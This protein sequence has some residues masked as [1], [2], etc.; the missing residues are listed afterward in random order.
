[1]GEPTKA[2]FLSYA[3]QDTEVARRI[4][5]ALRA[6]GVEVWF[7]QNELTG[8][9]AWDAKIRQQIKA[10]ALFVPI[11]SAA[12]QARAE[13]YFRREWKMA[14]ERTH[15]MADD[16]AFL[17]PVVIDDVPEAA[18]RVPEKFRE[19]QWT[20]LR[21]DE[22]PVELAQRVSRLLARPQGRSESGQPLLTAGEPN[23]ARRPGWT[24]HLGLGVG[25]VF[26]LVFGLRPFWDRVLDRDD[27]AEA[28]APT[29]NAEVRAL[30]RQAA[31][32][33][34]G[35]TSPT[36][37]DFESAEQLIARAMALD[38]TDP[39]IWALQSRHS[40]GMIAAQYDTS[41]ERVRK[42][43]E[44]A[45]RAIRLAP[46][47][48][49]ARLAHATALTLQPATWPEAEQALRQLAEEFP[50]DVRMARTLGLA[51]NA[52]GR[53]A[54]AIASFDRAIA[55]PG[56]DAQS[57]LGKSGALRAL[58][59]FEGAEARADELIRLDPTGP[60]Q[61]LKLELLVRFHGDLAG[62]RA[63]IDRIPARQ[64]REQS[65]AVVLYVVWLNLGEPD[66]AIA[67]LN[68]VPRDDLQ[69]QT[70]AG[71]K[72]YLIGYA[73]RLAGRPEAARAEWQ[74]ALNALDQRL[75]QRANDAQS[76]LQRA[77]LLA[78]LGRKA[79]AEEALHLGEQLLGNH[80]RT[81]TLATDLVYLE[82]GYVNEVI[83]Y[84]EKSRAPG[85]PRILSHTP[86]SLRIEPWWAPIR[87]DPRFQALT[88]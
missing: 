49:Y 61:V 2:V 57:L 54:E 72:G 7:D 66:R 78:C 15:D 33:F 35:S 24:R 84:L 29:R 28:S 23:L 43:T 82:L 52:Y 9:D 26:A 68:A 17:F 27:P 12:T 8:G 40:M 50:A 10:C 74:T 6:R 81:I 55:A 38:A 73:H 83:A 42:A 22:T 53:P 69:D 70:F 86:V 62:A 39:E 37:P 36:R 4:A 80:S 18:A 32:L 79:E 16:L 46:T 44:A 11:I 48:P 14:V 13:G 77:S 75:A 65:A 58:G 60:G 21:L 76:H 59:D 71:P 19:V 31:E 67:A 87:N 47:D 64:L 63:L 34:E 85:S 1:M 3:S 88:R 5:E 41:Q 20:R 56:G 51:L 30:A 25:L 45:D